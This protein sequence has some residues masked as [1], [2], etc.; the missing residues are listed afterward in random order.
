MLDQLKKIAP[1]AGLAVVVAGLIWANVAGA[2]TKAHYG[3]LIAGGLLLVA[4]AVLNQAALGEFIRSRKAL[5][6]A[7]FVISVVILLVVLGLANMLAVRFNRRLDTTPEKLYSLSDQTEKLLRGL[8]QPVQLTL[9]AKDKPQRII[10]LLE[11]YR[12]QSAQVR[13]KT[14]DPD[15]NPDQARRFNVRVYNTV[16]VEYGKRTEL[17]E[18]A[19]ESK[20]T[21]AILKVTRDQTKKVYFLEGHGEHAIS[22]VQGQGY[23]TAA[24]ALKKNNYEVGTVNLVQA[25]GVPADCRVLVVAGAQKELFDQ[26]VQWLEDYSKRGGALLVMADPTPAA[27]LAPLAAK[28]GVTVRNDLVLDTSNIS[29]LLGTGP[30]IPLVTQYPD[31]PITRGLRAMS[32]FPLVRSLAE[33]NPPAAGIALRRFLETGQDSWGETDL[34]GLEKSG[35]AQ[36]DEG[37]DLPGPLAIGLAAEREIGSGAEKKGKARLALVGDSDF[38]ANAYFNTQLNGDI[39]L[40]AVNWLAMDEELISIRPRNPA[41][42]R[43]FLTEAQMKLVFYCVVILLPL[44]PL[45]AG[46]VVVVARRRKR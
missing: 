29:Q 11:E 27:A 40:N 37:K 26:E 8:Q 12:S 13:W 23:S 2:W 32:L 35:T 24:A 38:A 43:I 15:R 16:V 34:D 9:F 45:V 39:F 42:R 1:L 20:L 22:D 18:D 14:L 25:K 19:D 6:G 46:V 10:D 17:V 7:N 36:F 5:H 21:A 41:D 30:G 31:H 44:I 4:G 28:W 3:V 33:A